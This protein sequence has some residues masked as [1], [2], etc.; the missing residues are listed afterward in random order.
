MLAKAKLLFLTVLV[1]LLS[2]CHHI[3]DDR[4][5][6]AAVHIAFNTIGDWHTWGVAGV[7]QPRSFILELREPSGFPYTA[8]SHTGFGG[9]ILMGDIHGNPIAYDLSC[10]VE[11]RQTTRLRF[12][13]DEMKLEC[14]VCHSTFDAVTNYGQPLSGPAAEKGY[15][16]RRY[17]VSPGLSGEY[18]VITR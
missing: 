16:L 3:D 9:V 12:L 11:A 5:P 1:T 7:G 6:P 18:K 2:G 13:Q 14:P 15:G 10:P 4:I 17:N 8:L